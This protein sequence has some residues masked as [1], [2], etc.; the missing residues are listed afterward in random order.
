MTATSHVDL[1]RLAAY[2]EGRLA[3]GEVE[4]LQEH[5]AGC[6]DCSQQLLDLAAWETALETSP[7]AAME[8]HRRH[9][10]V[11]LRQRIGRSETR[12]P[13]P[14]GSGTVGAVR[15]SG[16][17]WVA[18][19]AAV[20]VAVGALYLL[21][22]LGAL[23]QRE[24]ELAE[25]RAELAELRERMAGAA[26]EKTDGVIGVEVDVRP[27]FTVR[28]VA[29]LPPATAPAQVHRISIASGSA[30]TIRCDLTAFVD[31]PE[32]AFRLL[33]SQG[34]VWWEARRA[35]SNLHGDL[36]TEFSLQGLSSGRFYL[37]IMDSQETV[38]QE[39]ILEISPTVVD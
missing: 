33:D 8:D 29:E 2:R 30:V 28:D 24:S 15:E 35:N 10:L 37:R 5:L 3:A 23:D 4:E 20:V 16:L 12:P 25:A 9:R 38:L 19:A 6:P 22:V 31:L 17:R 13:L 11:A 34:L 7:T 32:L 1:D 21:Q 18:A 27:L 14:V 26:G 36:G 39:V